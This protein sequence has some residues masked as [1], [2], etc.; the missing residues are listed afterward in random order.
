MRV[1]SAELTAFAVVFVGVAVLSHAVGYRNYVR[2]IMD[3]AER[4]SG[5]MARVRQQKT[6]IR[7]LNGRARSAENNVKL[8]ALAAEELQSCLVR[9]ESERI[10]VATTRDAAAKDQPAVA[11]ATGDASVPQ[12]LAYR[13]PLDPNE[14]LNKLKQQYE[15]ENP[16]ATFPR[17]TVPPTIEVLKFSERLTVEAPVADLLRY[18]S[19]LEAQPLFLQVTDFKLTLPK[20]DAPLAAPAKAVLELSALGLPAE[21]PTEGN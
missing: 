19:K 14:Q 17:W 6:W 9:D 4:I 5:Q 12:R 13:I 8:L 10:K 1:T 7:S 21:E 18:M 3:R 20:P 15:V 2:P 11:V 16:R